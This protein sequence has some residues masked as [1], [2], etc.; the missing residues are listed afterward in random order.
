[1]RDVV[2][3]ELQSITTAK[4]GSF[5]LTGTMLEYE[6]QRVLIVDD[7]IARVNRYAVEKLV[8]EAGGIIAGKMTILAEGDAYGAMILYILNTFI[9]Q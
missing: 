3:I 9:V 4:S 1:M 5:I 2:S 7:V 6:R 8:T